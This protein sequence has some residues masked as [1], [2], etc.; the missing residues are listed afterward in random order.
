MIDCRRVWVAFNAKNV[1]GVAVRNGR[2]DSEESFPVRNQR[3]GI[4]FALPCEES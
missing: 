1:G 3:K 2:Q 4:V